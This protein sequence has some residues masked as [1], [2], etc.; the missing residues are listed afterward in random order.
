MRHEDHGRDDIEDMELIDDVIASRE[1]LYEFVLEGGGGLEDVPAADVA[2]FIAGVVRLVA[3]AAGHAVGRP[4]KPQ[5]T[6][7]LTG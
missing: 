1:Q 4:V 2:T 7:S 6:E 3:L 5:S